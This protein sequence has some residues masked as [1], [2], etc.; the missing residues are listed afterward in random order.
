MNRRQ[1]SKS[2]L[3]LGMGL[4]GGRS[5]E[6]AASGEA[7]LDFYQEAA[8][9]L[10]A[11]QFDVVVAGG[12][13]AGLVA[14]IAAARQG[15]KTVLIEIKGYPGGGVTEGG[16]A[17][18][19]FF[20]HWRPFPGVQKR[21]VVKGIPQ[22]II[23]R[24][25]K[26]GGCTGHGEQTIGPR[27][28][29]C[30]VVDTELYK[31]VGLQMMAEA[32]VYMCMNTML[33]GA[34][35]DGSRIRGVIA[36]SRAGREVFFAKSFVDSTGYGD[37]AAFAGAEYAEPNDY[38]VAN[39]MG[40]GNVNIDRLNEW[41]RQHD[42]L[43]ECAVGRRS[44]ED[45]RIIRVHGVTAKLPPEL[46]REAKEIGLQF[47]TTTVYDNYFMFV[48]LNLRLGKSPTNRDEVS[49]AELD[50]RQRQLLC[51]QLFKKWIP[52]CEK[53]FIA[54]T[55]P[56]LNIRRGRLITC[57]Y[58]MRHEDVIDGRHFEDDVYAFSYHDDARYRVK[59]GGTWGMPYKA[60]RP[61]GIENLL[62]A[63]MLVTSDRR[64]HQSTRNTVSCMAQ[65]QAAGT[66]AALCAPRNKG[67]R[68]L[69]YG[70]LRDALVKGGVYF[71][72]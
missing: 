36:E 27:D 39:A 69:P 54:R 34:I 62:V 3:L 59:D 52:G 25:V 35:K 46:A 8:R 22:E 70:Q 66:A 43:S 50:L 42:A 20:N 47:T 61:K 10:P 45:D 26:I 21:Q 68:E 64:A 58:D 29:S 38:D 56:T 6:V 11:R 15:A 67:T 30:T 53:A 12:G 23:D 1:F 14:A 60:L 19:S 40:L 37:L 71:E 63:G 57:D 13:T 17:L 9:K 32:G 31:L 33:V 48:K 72:S 55:A 7:S 4:A 51:L 41:V 24:L 18:H 2:G 5:H 49:K 28:S 44:G 16:T 65:G